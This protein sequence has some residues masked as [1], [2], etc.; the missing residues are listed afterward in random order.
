MVALDPRDRAGII[1]FIGKIV[2]R[3]KTRQPLKTITG[4]GRN[5]VTLI[6]VRQRDRYLRLRERQ[7]ANIFAQDRTVAIVVS[8]LDDEVGADRIG[9]LDC[10]RLPGRVGLGRRNTRQ[11]RTR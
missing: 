8:S 6:L 7:I 2:I 10:M 3:A 1:L 5:A 9:R 4:N 11:A